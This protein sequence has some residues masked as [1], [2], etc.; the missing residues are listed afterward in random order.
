MARI[1]TLTESRIQ[2]S[3]DLGF[4]DVFELRQQGESLLSEISAGCEIDLSNVGQAG[5]AALSLLLSWMRFAQNRNLS[6]E[7]SNPP[8]S[9]LGVAQVSELDSIIPFKQ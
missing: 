6:L 9:L 1:E 8:E 5:S 7:F 4:D 3:G 2:V